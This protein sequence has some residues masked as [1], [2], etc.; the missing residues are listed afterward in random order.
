MLM[1]LIQCLKYRKF[2]KIHFS[3]HCFVKLQ[4]Y[5]FPQYELAISLWWSFF[6]FS[7]PLVYILAVIFYG[8]AFSSTPGCKMAT[9]SV[10][11]GCLLCC[12]ANQEPL[13]F[14][15]QD[16]VGDRDGKNL[17]GHKLSQFTCR[18]P[19]EDGCRVKYKAFRSMGELLLDFE[20]NKNILPISVKCCASRLAPLMP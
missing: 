11:P 4:G 13:C 15:C 10:A 5:M 3:E 7:V 20:F 9:F 1:D 17:F 16:H 18:V 19:T 12:F 6:L 2:I 8:S 14:S